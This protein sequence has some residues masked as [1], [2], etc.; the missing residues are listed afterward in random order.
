MSRSGHW[1]QAVSTIL[2]SLLVAFYLATTLYIASHRPFW[3]D[4]ISTILI[5]RVNTYGDIWHALTDAADLP[6]PTYFMLVRPFDQW[7]GPGEI[8]VRIPSALAM[9]IGMLVTFDCS[10]RASNGLYGLIAVSLLTCSLLPYYGFEARP[11]SIYFALAAF[12]FWLWV[13][14][15]DRA[16]ASILFGTAF[17]LAFL[18]HYYSVL[19]LVPYAAA[20]ILEPRQW[21]ARVGKFA[22]GCVGVACGAALTLGPILAA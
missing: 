1:P 11:Y 10:R 5:A 15:K 20:V 22:A 7:F 12:T 2:L 4:E 13:H 3:F 16:F 6:P 19:C 8:G 14:T 18:V 21:R 17:F 9:I